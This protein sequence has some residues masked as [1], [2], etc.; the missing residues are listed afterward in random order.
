MRQ[1]AVQL[2]QDVKVAGTV[3]GGTT[4]TSLFDL[5][6]GGVSIFAIAA[7][8]ILS[9][10]LVTIHLLRWHEDQRQAKIRLN[11]DVQS[12]KQLHER[13]SLEN[14]VLTLELKAL[15]AKDK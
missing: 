12:S 6:Q 15:K 8:A 1:S 14:K 10:T 3:A 7:G 9:L 13:L 5:V 4:I 11:I 2:V